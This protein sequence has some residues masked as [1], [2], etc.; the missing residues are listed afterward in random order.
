[1]T[2]RTLSALSLFLLMP[3]AALAG[4]PATFSFGGTASD[5]TAGDDYKLNLYS[6]AAEGNL[7]G[8]DQRLN[9]TAGDT[10]TWL[11]FQRGTN[12]GY[13][14]VWSDTTTATGDGSGW[15]SVT[16][17][18]TLAADGYYAIGPHFTADASYYWTSGGTSYGWITNDGSIYGGAGS[19][20]NVPTSLQGATE[21]GHAYQQRLLAYVSST[22]DDNDNDNWGTFEGDCDDN[23]AAIN[24]DATEVCDGVD[25][26]CNGSI[27]DADGANW[28]P[29]SDGDGHGKEGSTPFVSC[30]APQGWV[31]SNDD[32]VDNND[33]VFPDAT[34]YC[35]EYDNDCDDVID[36]GCIERPEPED[37][38][39]SGQSGDSG[40]T[41]TDTDTGTSSDT[42]S[43]STDDDTDPKACGCTQTPGSTSGVG[44]LALI[45]LAGRRR[46]S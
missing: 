24:P 46:R 16:L 13:T 31:S 10:L 43:G 25:N 35:D 30:T 1:M 32:C 38:G 4:T 6:V 28:Y 29:D 33:H 2:I 19:Q 3:T 23:N 18:I 41:D 21:G 45:A 39:D 20:P 37:T 17:D 26:D 42:G 36:E 12:G 9:A 44:L 11:V 15:E 14:Q 34:E 27:D 7:V 22:G 8:I 5:N 40:T